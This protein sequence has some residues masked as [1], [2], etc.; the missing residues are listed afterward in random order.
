MTR[1]LVYLASA[2]RERLTFRLWS[3]EYLGRQHRS[4]ATQYA[5]MG[6]FRESSTLVVDDDERW[7]RYEQTVFPPCC[8]TYLERGEPCPMHE[9]VMDESGFSSGAAI[10]PRKDCL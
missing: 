8:A 4:D 10:V 9:H 1:L 6:R 7:D 3:K 5:S 2:I